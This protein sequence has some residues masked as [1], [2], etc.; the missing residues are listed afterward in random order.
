MDKQIIG[1]NYLANLHNPL[2]DTVRFL[3]FL[4]IPF[5]SLISYFQIKEKKFFFN[6]KN[7]IYF[8]FNNL[9]SN[10]KNINILFCLFLILVL[11]EFLTL[12]FTRYNFKLDIFHEGLWL[13]AS[14][15]YKLTGDLWLSSYIGRGFFG[16]FHPFFVWK[17]F[18]VESIGSTRFFN[19]LIIL[20]N[21][22]LLLMIA[23][24]I[25]LITGFEEKSKIIFF[26]LLSISF[27]YFTSYGEPVFIVRAFLLLVFILFLLNSFSTQRFNKIYLILIGLLSSLSMFW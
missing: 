14:E 8:N 11:I 16:N 20:M 27:L 23:R 25:T 21:K 24:K 1:E 15:N 12:N 26:T 2:N 13:T 22:F 7:I 19:L 5:V 17:L 10:K 3:I 4:I 18:G 9:S 6:L